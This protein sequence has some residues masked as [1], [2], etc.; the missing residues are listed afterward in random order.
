MSEASEEQ[1]MET[2]GATE[3][4]Y[5]A[6]PEGESSASTVTGAAAGAG[7][8]SAAPP[9]GNQNGAEGDQ[10][11]ASKNEEDAGQ[12]EPQHHFGTLFWDNIATS[13]TPM[14]TT[15]SFI[16]LWCEK[17]HHSWGLV[18]DNFRGEYRHPS[19]P[20]LSLSLQKEAVYGTQHR[21]LVSHLNGTSLAADLKVSSDR[22]PCV[23]LR[24]SPVSLGSRES[25]LS[26]GQDSLSEASPW[27][28]G[29]EG[30]LGHLREPRLRLRF[31]GLSK[32]PVFGIRPRQPDWIS[33]RSV[34]LSVSLTSSLLL[35]AT[36]ASE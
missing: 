34:P 5:G 11:N 22:F 10:I 7:G 20:F 35:Q 23:S 27:T 12:E 4:G 36:L 8:G 29:A 32:A 28:R 21:A 30:G 19:L 14:L 16:P 3:N 6:A 15:A 33:M 26:G 9:A 13:R 25:H 2:T 31:S 17:L 18:R 1:P 24:G